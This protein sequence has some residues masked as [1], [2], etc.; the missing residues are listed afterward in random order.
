[1]E[2]R[3]LRAASR[4]IYNTN[5][6]IVTRAFAQHITKCIIIVK[7]V[8]RRLVYINRKRERTTVVHCT[9]HG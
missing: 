8:D 5:A 3:E 2:K 9:Q 1:M 7:F 6:G 4:F